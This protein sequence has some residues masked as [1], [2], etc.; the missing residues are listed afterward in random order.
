MCPLTGPFK[1]QEDSPDPFPLF[2]TSSARP[3]QS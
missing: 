2:V 3:E 1:G